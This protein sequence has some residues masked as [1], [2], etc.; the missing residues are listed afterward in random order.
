MSSDSIIEGRLRLLQD[1]PKDTDDLDTELSAL[2]AQHIF[3][4]SAQEQLVPI[5]VAS[6]G[7]CLF[8]AILR[9]CHIT[10]FTKADQTALVKA[11]AKFTFKYEPDLG[12]SR[13]RNDIYGTFTSLQI[14][15]TALGVAIFV[16]QANPKWSDKEITE[17]LT[18][19][20]TPGQTFQPDY[21]PNTTPFLPDMSTY[22][23]EDLDAEDLDIHFI[24]GPQ[25]TRILLKH[26]TLPP[27][28]IIYKEGKGKYGSVDT[29]Y[30]AMVPD[31]LSEN[32]I[33]LTQSHCHT[34]TNYPAVLIELMLLT[35]RYP[36]IAYGCH[37]TLQAS[38][39]D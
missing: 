28:H 6:D 12:V 13:K 36:I 24:D 29:H 39:D 32:C 7:Y 21:M 5:D 9:S 35:I 11:L 31:S 18:F 22:A 20:I 1:L 14:I 34:I 17:Q 33:Q 38:N 2:Y 25:L 8:A 4:I 10:G 15:S 23:P 3:A 37:V 19:P 30:N 27:V 26:R 16:G